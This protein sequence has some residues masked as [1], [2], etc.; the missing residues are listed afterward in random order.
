MLRV[1][2]RVC[3]QNGCHLCVPT[4][5]KSAGAC[6]LADRSAARLEMMLFCLTF[7]MLVAIIRP[8]HIAQQKLPGN[9]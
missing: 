1:P 3:I 2:A 6:A 9:V 4:A 8:Y 5:T 7:T